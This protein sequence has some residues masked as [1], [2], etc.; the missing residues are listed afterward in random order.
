M[1]STY[2]TNLRIEL[3]AT[4]EN[5]G[6]WGAKANSSALALLEEA[7]AGNVTVAL[8]DA[9]KTLTPVNGATD[10]ARPMFLKFTGT[11]TANRTIT[12]PTVSKLYMMQNATTGGFSLIITTGGGTTYTLP[13]SGSPGTQWKL[14]FTDGISVWTNDSLLTASSST[15]RWGIVPYVNA[16]GIM[17]IGQQIDFHNTNTDAND[18]NVR[19][20][21]GGTT[22]DLYV[23]PQG[24]VGRK[25]WNA[26]NDGAGSLLDADMLDGLHASDIQFA[27]APSDGKQYVRKNAAWVAVDTPFTIEV[28]TGDVILKFGATTVVRIK[29]TGLIL[30]KD[31]IEVFSV[32]V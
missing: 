20:E 18:W 31:D 3:Q 28:A 27:D 19:L 5:R 32:S 8:T 4:G 30:T 6:S 14:V 22:S 26:G 1:A 21:T 24:G 11:L 25:I 9:N 15:Q 2:S 12:I 10:Q 17:E 23:T 29:S 16:T 13:P 7:I